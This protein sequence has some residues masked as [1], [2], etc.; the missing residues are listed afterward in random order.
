MNTPD[1]HQRP[2]EPIQAPAQAGDPP[3]FNPMQGVVASGSGGGVPPGDYQA[4]FG[5]AEY[6]PAAEP[7]PMTGKGGRK[8]AVVRFTW[9]VDDGRLATRETPANYG[10][11]SGFM[12]VV[13][14]LLGRTLAPGEPFDLTACASRRY[15]ITVRPKQNRAGQPTGWNEV[16]ACIPLPPQKQ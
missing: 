10:S 1:K 12:Q 3:A 5:G 11:K 13:G 6:L 2:G 4:D 14:W 7:D 15:L 9:R 8:W 16:T